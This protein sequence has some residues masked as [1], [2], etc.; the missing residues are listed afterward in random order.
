MTIRIE[1]KFGEG[2]ALDIVVS[3]EAVASHLM[4]QR[5]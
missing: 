4:S 5:L 3:V 1:I 2:F